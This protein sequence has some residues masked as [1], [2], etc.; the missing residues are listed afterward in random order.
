MVAERGQRYENISLKYSQ[1]EK[2]N[3][4]IKLTTYAHANCHNI[5]K[6]RKA[7]QIAQTTAEMCWGL[8]IVTNPATFC[9]ESMM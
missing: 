7:L 9:L 8:K 3:I 4:I 1:M 5:C 2:K 6:Y